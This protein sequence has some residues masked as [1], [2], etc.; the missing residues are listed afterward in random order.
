MSAVSGEL[1]Y[2]VASWGVV[3]LL[4]VWCVATAVRVIPPVRDRMNSVLGSGMKFIPSYRFFAPDPGR[5]DFHLLYRVRRE[6]E[7]VTDWRHCEDL[8]DFPQY[9]HWIWNPRMYDT[10]AMSDYAQSLASTLEE[11]EG[12]DGEPEAGMEADDQDYEDLDMVEGESARLLESEEM[13]K[14]VVSTPYLSLLNYVTGEADGADAE[15]VQFLIMR[16]S[17]RKGESSEPFFLSYFHEV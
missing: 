4:A 13:E 7:E 11:E 3:S 6:D 10:K 8:I 14:Y 17:L 2:Q 5:W 15:E 9:I 12:R 1:I 16:G